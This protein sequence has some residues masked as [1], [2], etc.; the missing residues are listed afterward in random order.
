[1]LPDYPVPVVD[2]RAPPGADESAALAALA[3]AVCRP[4]LWLAPGLMVRAP[5]LSGA[6]TGKGLLVRVL[7]AIA[8]GW[9]PHAVTPGGTGEELEKR[10][11]S[12]LMGAEP[13]LFLDNAN[14][15]TLRS[16]ALASAITERPAAVRA[17]GEP[18]LCGCPH[19]CKQIFG[20]VTAVQ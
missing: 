12:A 2:L 19:E 8:F 9:A 20:L 16:D 1:L 15:L 3:T 14:G 7:C 5:A 17:L 13:V 10:V 11:V 18:P 6:A 4:S